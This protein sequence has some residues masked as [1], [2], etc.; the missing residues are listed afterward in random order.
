MAGAPP[1]PRPPPPPPPPPL[2]RWS[3]QVT[4]VTHVSFPS[5]VGLVFRV[6]P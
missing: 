6:P 2:A 4:Y 5:A 3:M 1:P